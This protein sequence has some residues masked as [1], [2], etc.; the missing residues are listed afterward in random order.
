VA[1]VLRWA[2]EQF[3]VTRK[4]I[5]HEIIG[6][7]VMKEMDGISQFNGILV[8]KM[9]AN[10]VVPRLSSFNRKTVAQS[11]THSHTLSLPGK[12]FSPSIQRF[13]S[14]QRN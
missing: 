10:S 12:E 8:F 14:N 4:D 1:R 2:L 13:D 9:A 6:L 7:G 11:H 5:N 3:S